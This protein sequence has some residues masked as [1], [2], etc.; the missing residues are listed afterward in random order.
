MNNPAS[1]S[2]KAVLLVNLGTPDQPTPKAVGRF[3]REF[4]S[5]QRVIEIPRLLWQ[6]IL[7]LLVIPLRAKRVAHAYE[8]IW[9]K[10]DSPM[11]II[12]TAQATA[13]ADQLAAQHPDVDVVPVMSYGNPALSAALDRLSADGVE[14][15]IVLPLFPQYSATSTGPVYDVVSRWMLAQRNLPSVTLIKDYFDH[16]LYIQA[17]ADSVRR[18]QAIH[19]QPEKLLM[20]FHGIPQPYADRG[21]PYPQRCQ[22]TAKLLAQALGLSDDAWLIS[23]QS[24]F[25]RQE[26]VKPYTNITL[27]E[28][29]KS[30]VKSVQ[31]I[32]PAFSA[33]CLETLEEL[34]VENRETFLAAGGQTY[35]YIPALNDDALHID[36]MASLV[37]PLL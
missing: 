21:D 9:A 6:I 4:L 33:D 32:S 3:L 16:P 17:L 15:I 29:A 5:D 14:Q 22:A 35:D 11:R 37:R 10:G 31:I 25:G 26:W 12:L 19:G 1:E 34:A 18:Y 36:M 28:W 7:N 2:K 13:L 20:S 30:G 24:R 23:F 8:S 27:A